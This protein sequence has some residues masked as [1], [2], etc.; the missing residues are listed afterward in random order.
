MKDALDPQ[1]MYNF[2]KSQDAE[3]MQ[4]APKSTWMGAAGSFKGFEEDYDNANAVATARLEYNPVVSNGVMA[5]PPTRVAPPMPSQGFYSNITQASEEIKA[6]IGLFDPSL[7][8]QGN[9]VAARAILAR[10]QQGDIST[11]HYTMVANIALF[12]GG[13]VIM[14]LI[15]HIYDTARTIRILGDDMADEVVKINQN[16]ID[17]DGNPKLYDL[18]V[19]EYDV[20]IDIGAS[21]ATR[22]MDA[23]ENLLEFARVIP[24]AGELG[25]D[26]IVGNMDFEKS[27]E[28]SMRFRAALPPE[29]LMKVDMMQKGMSIE[30]I[31]LQQLQ[32]QLQQAG[33]MLQGMGEENKKLKQKIGQF[34]I[35]ETTIDAN[36]DITKEKIK[37]GADIEKELIRQR[38]NPPMPPGAGPVGSRNY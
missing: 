8:A 29:L 32:Q 10:Q 12:K 13:I 26:M 19:G 14:D 5:P 38:F 36:A 27:E 16:F 7:G 6:C 28:L 20:K 34:N 31:Q 18:T 21:S 23:A 15:P 11:H 17:K 9:E 2:Y 30:Q 24:K 33:Q 1:R 35:E 3:L 4:Q 22:R 25:A 37:A